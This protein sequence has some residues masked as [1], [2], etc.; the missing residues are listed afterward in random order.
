MSVKMTRNGILLESSG[1]F[2][3]IRTSYTIRFGHNSAPA[4]HFKDWSEMDID[5][6]KEVIPV[7]WTNIEALFKA[8][9]AYDNGIEEK[10]II[11]E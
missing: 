6:R 7:T 10:P 11:V 5:Y 2:Y 4:F 9:Q 3:G 8:L 1:K